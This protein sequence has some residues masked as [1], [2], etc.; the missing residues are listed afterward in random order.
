MDQSRFDRNRRERKRVKMLR[1]CF[2]ELKNRPPQQWPRKNKRT[3]TTSGDRVSVKN[4]ELKVQDMREKKA[5]ETADTYQAPGPS[6][7]YAKVHVH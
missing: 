5:Q 1:G 7:R 3:N 6:C 2:D 4:L